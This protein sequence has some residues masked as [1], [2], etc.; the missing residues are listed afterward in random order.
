MHSLVG[1][2]ATNLQNSLPVA[3][4][5]GPS[6]IGPSVTYGMWTLSASVQLARNC[7]E[8]GRVASSKVLSDL[9]CG[10]RYSV[11]PTAVGIP[12]AGMG[13]SA[14]ASPIGESIFIAFAR[15]DLG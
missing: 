6:V 9:L 8:G 5:T 1:T 12:L 3:Y 11:E 7:A 10:H 4:L 14:P 15:H 13:V 2:N